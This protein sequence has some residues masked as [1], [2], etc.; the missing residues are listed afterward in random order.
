MNTPQDDHARPGIA[1]AAELLRSRN[2]IL[3]TTH[4]NPDGDALGCMCAAARL[5]ALLGKETRLVCVSDVPE[6][7]AWLEIPAPL[8]KNY[9]ELRGWQPDLVLF[10][11]CGHPSRSGPDGAALAD[12]HMPPGWKQVDILNI[13]HHQ[14]TP[15]FGL[16]NLV[17]PGAGAT[18]EL[19]GLIIEYLGLPLSGPLGE[20]IYLGLSSDSGNFSY[21]NT[22]ADLLA[23]AGRIVRHGFNVEEFM[24]KS[25]NNWSLGRLRL[26]A[27]TL[28]QLRFFAQDQVALA[29]ISRAD[30]DKHQCLPG[31][32]DQLV[33]FPLRLR[34]ARVSVLIREKIDGGSK[35]SLRS[36]GGEQGPDVRKA[37]ARLGGGGHRNAAGAEVNL[38]PHKAEEKILEFLMEEMEGKAPLPVKSPPCG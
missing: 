4:R 7:L 19:L 6:H 12:G 15:S 31:D 34:S 27:E 21:A 8:F 28:L 23:M 38:P 16:V 36:Q 20:A 22:N 30:M 25:E 10:L 35:L 24:V 18:A 9:A 17:E 2:R 32:L 29:R 33:S 5:C 1:Q 14:H 26:W 3:I 37:A 11:D 13:D